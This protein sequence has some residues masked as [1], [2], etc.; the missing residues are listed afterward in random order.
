MSTSHRIQ[1]YFPSLVILRSFSQ[2]IVVEP[3]LLTIL[4]VF[5]PE[6]DDPPPHV[7]ISS[8]AHPS[9]AK[10]PKPKGEVTRIARDGYNLLAALKWSPEKYVEVQTHLQKL[11]VKHLDLQNTFKKQKPQSLV[12]FHDEAK[13]L[14]PVLADYEDDWAASDFLRVYLKNAKARGGRDQEED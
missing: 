13:K 9:G 11:A 1:R 10:I 4:T 5:P 14:Y 8:V 3:P 2:E 7:P 12:R 6:N